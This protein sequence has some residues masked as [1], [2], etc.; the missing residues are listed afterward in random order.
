MNTSTCRGTVI[1]CILFLALFPSTHVTCSGTEPR[2]I[3]KFWDKNINFLFHPQ[4]AYNACG[5]A[6]VQMVLDFFNVDPLPSQEQLAAEMNTTIFTYTYTNHIST[7]IRNRDVQI[8]FDGHLSSDF[9]VALEELQEDVSRN[10][11]VI[12]LTWYDSDKENGH[13]RVV[14]GY[15]ETGLFLH[16]PWDQELGSGLYY[17]PNIFL[18][19]SLF[20][21]LWT[22]YNNWALVLESGEPYEIAPD[23]GSD[24]YSIPPWFIVSIVIITAS[25]L[26]L[27]HL[28]QRRKPNESLTEPT[29]LPFAE[30]H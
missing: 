25:I 10:Q 22:K 26:V 2:K 29:T 28:R 23:V 5:P 18:G 7:P 4:V 15:N 6:S 27:F 24:P 9:P 11:P 12:V 20:E 14:T 16:D 30:R 8:V 21:E 13:F 19:N 1:L 17:G 3:P